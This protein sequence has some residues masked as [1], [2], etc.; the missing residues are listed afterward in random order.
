MNRRLISFLLLTAG[1]WCARA[2]SP[3]GWGTNYTAALAQA[4]TQ[5]QPVLAYFTASWCGPCKRMARTTLTNEAVLRALHS[6]SPVAVDIDERRDLAEKHGIRAVPT[7]QILTAA[8]DAVSATTG[9]QEADR[10]LR[11]LT[12]GLGNAR[13]AARRQTEARETLARAREWLKAADAE[14]LRQAAAALADLCAEPE[15]AVTAA[16]SERLADMAKRD[17]TLLLEGLNHPRL[18]ARIRVA[19]VLRARIG[20][21]FDVDPW[22]DPAT[23]RQAVARWRAKLAHTPPTDGRNP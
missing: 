2:E 18:A 11:W 16:A 3:A 10:F 7:F 19:N 5:Q 17:A 20:D 12:N 21:G 15:S 23:R 4:Q 13:E 6:F 1:A 22:S 9:Y 8:G 14:S